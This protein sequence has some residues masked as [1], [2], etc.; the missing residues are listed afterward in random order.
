MSNAQLP[1]YDSTITDGYYE[2]LQRTAGKKSEAFMVTL[3]NGFVHIQETLHSYR[4]K[5][6]FFANMRKHYRTM[7]GRDAGLCATSDEFFN[8]KLYSALKDFFGKEETERIRR[9]CEL[10]MEFPYSHTY[11]RPSYRSSKVFEYVDTFF[12]VMVNALRFSCYGM[13][14]QQHTLASL[15]YLSGADNRLAMALRSGD[16]AIHAMVEE[17]IIGDNSVVS[18]SYTLISA[19]MKSGDSRSLDLLGKLLLAAKGQEGV[20]QSILELCDSGVPASH[21]YFLRLIMENDLFRFSSVIRAFDTWTGLSYGDQKQRVAEK[22]GALALRY[23]SEPDAIEQGLGSNDVTEI[24]LALWV[25][26]CRDIHAAT[27][28][29]V[30]LLQNPEKYRRLVGW[31]FITS[32]NSDVFR[33]ELAVRHLEVL[34]GEE[35]AWVFANLHQNSKAVARLYYYNNRDVEKERENVEQSYYDAIYPESIEQRTALFDAIAQ[36]IKSLPDKK[37]KTFTESVFPWYTQELNP[38]T[39]CATLL[40]LAAYDKNHRLIVRLAEFLPFMESDLRLAY[41]MRL[42]NPDILEQRALLLDGLSDKSPSVR[43]SI[44]ERLKYYTITP[45]DVQR[46]AK[47]LNTKNARLRKGILSLLGGQQLDLVRPAIDVLLISKD[48]NQLIAGVELLEVFSKQNPDLQSEYGERVAELSTSAGTGKDVSIILDK[49]QPASASNSEYTRENG[50]GLFDPG[51]EVFKTEVWA[52]RRPTVTLLDNEQLKAAVIAD[53]EEAGALFERLSTAVEQ[54]RDYEYEAENYATGTREKV[55][56]GNDIRYGWRK[57][58]AGAGRGANGYANRVIGNYPLAEKWVEAAADYATSV[59]KLLALRSVRYIGLANYLRYKPWFEELFAEYPYNGRKTAW[60]YGFYEQQRERGVNEHFADEIVSVLF[61]SLLAGG[62]PGEKDTAGGVAD[63]RLSAK[64]AVFNFAFSTYVNLINK[65]P[66]ARLGDDAVKDVESEKTA[67]HNSS[68]LDHSV[69]STDYLVFWRDTAYRGIETDEQFGMYFSEMWYEFL[70]SGQR[71]LYGL[72]VEDLLRAHDLNLIDDA[73]LHLSFTGAEGAYTR[74]GD[75]TRSHSRW[76][77]LTEKYPRSKAVL[78]VTI[79]R[80]VS[81]EALRGEIPTDLTGVA[82]QIRRFDG[83]A[84]HFVNLLTALGNTGFFRGYAY[85]YSKKTDITK[86]ECLSLLLKNCQPLPDD[87]PARLGKMLEA[88]KIKE[89]RIIEAAAYAPQWATLLEQATGIRGLKCGVWFFHAHINERFSAEKET[90]VALYSAITPRQFTD[91]TFDKDWFYEAY[92]TLGEK[93]FAE[94]YKS[95]KYITDSSSNHRRSQLY[96]DA[97]L[98]RLDLAELKAEVA[99]KRN[100]E[101]LR[102][103]A[104]V[105]LDSSNPGDAL[106]RY[107]YIQRFKK[108]SRQFGAQR[109]ASEGKAVQTALENLAITTG[110]SE[111]DRMIWALEGEKIEELKPLMEPKLLGDTEVK[112]HIDDDGSAR[113]VVM[114][115]GKELKA[116]PKALNKDPFVLELKEAVKGL[117]DQKSRACLSFETAMVLRTE[118]KAEELVGLLNH[119][120]LGSSVANLVFAVG[121][122]PMLGFP[123][124]FG[125]KLVLV[126]LTG[127]AEPIAADQPIFIAHP[128]HMV[129][130]GSWSEF[131]RYVYREQLVQPFKQ[132]FREYYPVTEDELAAVNLSR[133][134]AGNQVQP[135]KTHAL[136]K[137]R[138]WTVDYEQGLQRVWHKEDLVV[139]MYALADWFSPAEIEAPTLET[140]QFFRRDKY[141]PV[142]FTDVAPVLFSEAMRDI[143]LVVSVAHAGGVDPEASHS[144]IEMRIAITR[145]LLT[146]LSVDN[147]TFLETHAKIKGSL[148]EYSVHMGSGVIHKSGTGMIAVLPVHSQARGRIFLPFADDDPKTAEVLS[149]I[150]LLADDAKIKDP[151]ILRQIRG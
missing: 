120:V 108:E 5:D 41:Y 69:L 1:D 57:L 29:A 17:A 3:W 11:Y 139:R 64:T 116:V 56:L 103:L 140:V 130:T 117:R 61:D 48:S 77:E 112:L 59:P 22:C 107:E 149:K 12:L 15:N 37:K 62:K 92:G 126:A 38:S 50:Y 129:E 122:E 127:T 121:L 36:R 98:G 83:G 95:A 54:N 19:V 71:K 81:L 151:I 24:Y 143:D 80:V 63:I 74:M 115:G 73:A 52:A 34:D 13:A 8:R 42:I 10:V 118:F 65:I 45:E 114:K 79:D 55:L 109:Q 46:L 70:A 106:E 145:E 138:G 89:K 35:L 7:C 86:K 40:S 68:R 100:Q 123:K 44:V 82:Y 134:Y 66:R 23:L 85:Y 94:L 102:A 14:L 113:I 31:Y 131:Q 53:V 150:L 128:H 4:S 119:P 111:V 135:K 16:A 25:L 26:G 104:L 88:A 27:D 18:P 132:V 91:G 99:N 33:H 78:E 142:A 60:V 72:R 28:S 141:E 96:A 133:R 148:G 110:Y 76:L 39:P 124:V 51:A 97:I 49:I 105:P 58:V 146:L 75:V 67:W 125:G 9:E 21:T 136:L 32:A 90:E 47:L 6:E 20:R 84:G 137:T 93:R 147:V 144:T 2:R 43:E 101:K 87:T 30:R